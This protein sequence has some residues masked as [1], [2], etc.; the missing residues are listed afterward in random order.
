MNDIERLKRIENDLQKAPTV[1]YLEGKT[2]PEIFFALLGVARPGSSIHNDV[3][4]VGLSKGGSGGT[5]VQ[6]LVR[7]A[8]NNNQAG[9]LGQGGIFGVIDG[10]GR[11][12]AALG[13]EFDNPFVGP[14]FSWK[15]YCI[16]NMLA[17][18]A[19]PSAWG[20][21]SN[22][23]NVLDQYA[24]YAALN[25]V[26]RSLQN[27]L[28]TLHLHRFR[29]PQLGQALVQADSIQTTLEQDKGL[30]TGRDVAAEFNAELAQVQADISSSLDAGHTQIN[31]K[32][33]VRHYAP[34]TANQNE[35]QCRKNWIAAV[36]N[37][38]GLAE[39]RNWWQ[40]VTGN[41]P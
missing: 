39:V 19:W 13:G 20:N 7:V 23:T 2:D 27:D 29:N 32:W 1:I 15:A 12:L 5:E 25:R 41:A 3:Y 21:E 34:T 22:W 33:F 17:K 37:A 4:V 40:R 35:Q 16:E 38:G 36:Q 9:Q 24:P 8:D 11:D 30:I 18:T 26:H 28:K 14:V 31:G 10:D 6:E